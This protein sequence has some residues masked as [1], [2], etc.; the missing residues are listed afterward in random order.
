MLS[1]PPRITTS[2]DLTAHF[3]AF[4]RLLNTRL[5]TNITAFVA[6]RLEWNGKR[7]SSQTFAS[8][9]VPGAV[10]SPAMIVADVSKRTLAVRMEIELPT[11]ES[12]APSVRDEGTSTSS[13]PPVRSR[14]ITEHVFYHFN[15]NWLID[16][17]WSVF[18]HGDYGETPSSP[19]AKMASRSTSTLASGAAPTE[20]GAPAS[21]PNGHVS[22]STDDELFMF[23]PS[24]RPS[25]PKSNAPGARPS[26]DGMQRQKEAAKI[27]IQRVREARARGAQQQKQQQQQ[28]RQMPAL[29]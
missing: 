21:P 7:M 15:D 28:Q 14:F 2:A 19:L 29:V 8:M 10:F 26:C 5:L 12:P 17:V 25:L 1:G 13:T 23:G 3:R 18:S 22:E 20:R 27:A 6:P 11:K 16:E 9:V 4:L 24:C